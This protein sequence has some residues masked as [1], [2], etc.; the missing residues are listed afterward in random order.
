MLTRLGT[1]YRKQRIC[2][3]VSYADLNQEWCSPFVL[4][5]ASMC[6]HALF[7]DRILY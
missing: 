3:G 6:A 5:V 2:L 1:G 7:P 4:T